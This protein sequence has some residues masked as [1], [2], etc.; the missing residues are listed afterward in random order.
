MQALASSTALLPTLS[1]YTLYGGMSNRV[2]LGTQN[3]HTKIEY[4]SIDES[5]LQIESVLKR[6]Q[7]TIELGL[8]NSTNRERNNGFTSVCRHWC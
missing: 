7:D 3:I 1:N 6:Y 8:I 4:Y 5:F 2:V